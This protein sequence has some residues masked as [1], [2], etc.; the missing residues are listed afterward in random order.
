MIARKRGSEMSYFVKKRK[1]TDMELRA[2]EAV[3]PLETYRSTDDE[4]FGTKVARRVGEHWPV[5]AEEVA[6]EFRKMTGS[7]VPA[8]GIRGAVSFE[9]IR[10]HQGLDC[11]LIRTELLVFNALPGLGKLPAGTRLK[12]ASL[13]V[14]SYELLPLELDLPPVADWLSLDMAAVLTDDSQQK[15]IDIEITGLIKAQHEYVLLDQ[16]A[17][18]EP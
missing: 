15:P 6:Q 17:G 4:L 5:N 3:A 12:S 14:Q 1:F 10:E 8:S 18:A 9:E 13:K 7:V 16:A 2:L 11:Q